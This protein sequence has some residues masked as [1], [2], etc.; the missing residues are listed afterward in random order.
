MWNRGKCHEVFEFSLDPSVR[1]KCRGLLSSVADV[2]DE[3]FAS[4]GWQY[5]F[6]D[7]GPKHS[8]RV[9]YYALRFADK[10]RENDGRF[11]DEELMCLA[12]AC[13]LHDLGMVHL[14][15]EVDVSNGWPME[16]IDEVR[17][18][19]VTEIPNILLRYKGELRKLYRAYPPLRDLLPLV[20]MGHGT[21]THQE[22]CD[23]IRDLLKGS[24]I[25][26]VLIAKILLMSD[27]LDLD[28]TRSSY[29]THPQRAHLPCSAQAHQFKHHVVRRVD[30]NLPSVRLQYA[31]P[32]GLSSRDRSNVIGWIHGKLEI[33]REMLASS[34]PP[35]LE[36]VF[37]LSVGVHPVSGAPDGDVPSKQV[38]EVIR[39]YA[40]DC[41]RE[42]RP[43]TG[44][45]A[46]LRRPNRAYPP[47]ISMA[48][49]GPFYPDLDN[50][51]DEFYRENKTSFAAKRFGESYVHVPHN[52][53]VVERLLA[54]VAQHCQNAARGAGHASASH[55]F[56]LT[57]GRGVGKSAMVLHLLHTKQL[58]TSFSSASRAKVCVYVDCRKLYHADVLTAIIRA[59]AEELK[60]SRKTWQA[61]NQRG[62]GDDLLMELPGLNYPRE[63]Q[64]RLDAVFAVLYRRPDLVLERVIPVCVLLDNLDRAASFDT[65]V[66]VVSFANS[67]SSRG[68]GFF[69][70]PLRRQTKLRLD[71]N[72][73]FDD[74][75]AMPDNSVV[76]PTPSIVLRERLTVAFSDEALSQAT[77]WHS[78]SPISTSLGKYQL[79]VADMRECLRIGAETLAGPTAGNDGRVRFIPSMCGPNIRDA[80][81]LYR[82]IMK[83]LPLATVLAIAKRAEPREHELIKYA[84]LDMQPSY[85]GAY[86]RIRNL[87]DPSIIAGEQSYFMCLYLLT[88]LRTLGRDSG[89][90][91][92]ATGEVLREAREFGIA[93][94]SSKALLW[95]MM[96]GE[97]ALVDVFDTDDVLPDN[98]YTSFG[99]ITDETEVGLS[100]T[101]T[102]YLDYLV[103]DATYLENILQDTPLPAHVADR[104]ARPPSSGIDSVRQ[105]DVF[106]EFLE[107]REVQERATWPGSRSLPPLIPE[108][109]RRFDRQRGNILGSRGS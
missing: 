28:S 72:G 108:F 51:F 22:A 94:W 6:T 43:R 101:G 82:S 81:T 10:V 16:V 102:Y 8:D 37:E 1:R 26:G 78:P 27:E 56:I 73:L 92:M 47:M 99:D 25:R 50:L 34:L 42:L 89:S 39:S 17:R 74:A 33:Q 30:D 31:F 68:S 4:F 87:F 32:E 77:R 107:R 100:G 15:P 24:E 48:A 79:T 57:G 86:S 7:H 83:Q 14:P 109:K 54:N 11:S 38:L 95:E 88:L 104:L 97:F 71:G 59:L 70:A 75:G 21:S 18:R 29:T 53:R 19:H 67:Y 66:Q 65:Q 3:A 60:R 23:R 98:E 9:F 91:Y 80:L 45:E 61:L 90:L 96:V 36:R 84:M 49:H 62:L 93:P 13:Y 64:R 35:K 69:V 63:L 103:Y 5:W 76:N 105:I 2:C 58:G 55:P 106:L 12:A 52:N 85:R 40:R 44:D 46:D 20:C 41:H